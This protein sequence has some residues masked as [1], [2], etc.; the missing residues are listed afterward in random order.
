[1][2]IDE[3]NVIEWSNED[4]GYMVKG[5]VDLDEF[6]DAIEAFEFDEGLLKNCDEGD[7]RVS[8]RYCCNATKEESNQSGYD[9]YT[10]FCEEG[11]Y[12]AYPVT[13]AMP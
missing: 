3:T 5:H 2:T 4:Y 8:H 1:M 9:G 11:E 12:G 10:L 13:V 7:Y 6:L